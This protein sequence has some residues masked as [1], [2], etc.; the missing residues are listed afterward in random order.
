M[1]DS[2]TQCEKLLKGSS[3]T[4][5]RALKDMCLAFLEFRKHKD[6]SEQICKKLDDAIYRFVREYLKEQSLTVLMTRH[7]CLMIHLPMYIFSSYMPEYLEDCIKQSTF[8]E[9]QR[10][11][12]NDVYNYQYGNKVFSQMNKMD[13]CNLPIREIYYTY[14]NFMTSKN[15]ITDDDLKTIVQNIFKTAKQT[16]YGANIPFHKQ[17][18]RKYMKATGYDVPEGILLIAQKYIDKGQSYTEKNAVADL[19]KYITNNRSAFIEAQNEEEKQI[20]KTLD[21]LFGL[22]EEIS[23]E[24]CC[25]CFKKPASDYKYNFGINTTNNNEAT[26]NILPLTNKLYLDE[27]EFYKFYKS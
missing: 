13:E 22:D 11:F 5:K 12:G 6:P 24:P 21:E 19:K 15:N 3:N 2:K 25:F 20:K 23:Y 17:Y 18:S 10:K 9:H 7:D 8:Y 4:F 14:I 16:K 1:L 26:Y 27:K